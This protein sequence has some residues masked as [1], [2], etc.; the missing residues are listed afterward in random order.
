MKAR[1]MTFD[2]KLGLLALPLLLAACAGAP[3][4][5][6]PNTT[7]ELPVA[8]AAAQ[9]PVRADWWTLYGDAQLN[10][11]V[12]EALANNTDLA[13]AAARIDE[14]RALVRL[15]RADALPTVGATAGAARQ[16]SGANAGLP[17]PVTA[18]NFN[19]GLNVSWELDLWGRLAAGNRAAREDLAATTLDRDALRT[20][21][22]A[23]VVQAY[24][25]V[26]SIDAQTAA[27]RETV[28]G[29]RD[30]VR[31]QRLREQGGELSQLDLSQIEA[32]L[33]GNESQLLKLDRARGETSR[34]LA[35]VL[36]RSPRAVWDA[37]I[38]APAQ[39]LAVAGGVPAGLP[40]TLLQ[41][42]PDVAAAEARLRAA[43]ARVDVAR[44][45]YLPG[46]ALSA[47][48]GKAS[49]DL[50]N[51]LDGPSTIWSLVASLTQPI[52]NAG[53]LDAGREAVL[54]RQR[55]AELDYRDAVARAFREVRDALD[56]QAEASASLTLARQRA[57]ALRQAARLTQLRVD[58][59]ESS[60]LNAIEAQ[61]I[62][63][64]AQSQ[65]ADQQRALAVAQAD[66]FRALGGGWVAEASA[67]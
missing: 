14:S 19:L 6:A 61:R 62:A 8:T 47:S 49:T 4:A 2:F 57:D 51:L 12:A 66:L 56:A 63:L 38:A 34:A 41:Q 26:Q 17:A 16:R 15:A 28:A 43:G 7:M 52:W 21:L 9:Q 46:V 25:A 65:M 42:R 53:R 1:N 23:Q 24:A 44:A 27:F 60:R 55:Q 18:N 36:G 29:Q 3:P 11:L 50:S 31:L 5:V 40:S 58:A 67:R 33:A 37:S 59:G 10:A 22:A 13:R 35:T 64:A 30:G 39:P 48:L 32:E 54:A 45:A 20:A